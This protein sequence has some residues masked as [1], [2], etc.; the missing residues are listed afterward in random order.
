MKRFPKLKVSDH[1]LFLNSKGQIQNSKK[2]K[3]LDV[4]IVV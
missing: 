3:N 2:E 4:N 1:I